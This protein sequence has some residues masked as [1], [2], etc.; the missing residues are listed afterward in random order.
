MSMNLAT[1]IHTQ[2]LWQRGG[3]IMTYQELV[4]TI[5]TLPL[6]ERLSLL[7]VLAASLQAEMKVEK[8][9]ASSISSVLGMLKPNGPTPDDNE[10]EDAYTDYLIEKY[11]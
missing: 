8:N 9:R 6:T 11:A 10:L 1:T 3:T 5:Q 4:K 2:Q 7:E